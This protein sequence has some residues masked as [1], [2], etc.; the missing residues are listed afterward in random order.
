MIRR[1]ILESLN[2]EKFMDEDMD[3]TNY[4]LRV[5]KYDWPKTTET[6]LGLHCHT[7]KNIATIL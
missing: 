3:S 4:L 1:M 7:D 5:M 2:L 6:K